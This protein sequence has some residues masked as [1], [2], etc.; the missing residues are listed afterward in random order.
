MGTTGGERKLIWVKST[1]S[2]Q[3][4]CVEWTLDADDE[5][6]LIRDSKDPDGS[7][8]RFTLSEWRAFIAGVK[9]GEANL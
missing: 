1:L 3:S 4:D 6:V 9:R 5:N 2:Q 7:R 8:L